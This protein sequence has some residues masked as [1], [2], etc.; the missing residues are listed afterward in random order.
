[1]RDPHAGYNQYSFIVHSP[2]CR[3][4]ARHLDG[5]AQTNKNIVGPRQL[6]E[7]REID[8]VLGQL[9]VGERQRAPPHT[10]YP[11]VAFIG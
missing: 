10:V 9:G 8:D 1:M 4:A 6:R 2:E 7:R 5:G 11:A 3:L